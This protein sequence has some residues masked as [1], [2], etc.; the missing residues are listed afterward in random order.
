MCYLLSLI[1]Q[2]FFTLTFK[3]VREYELFTYVVIN[4]NLTFINRVQ[5]VFHV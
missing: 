2:D 3:M 5:L 1:E 4:R